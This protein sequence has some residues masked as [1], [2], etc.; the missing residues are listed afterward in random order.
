MRL[1]YAVA[2]SGL[3]LAAGAAMADPFSTYSTGFGDTP[4]DKVQIAAE[5][6]DGMAQLELGHRYYDG[7]PHKDDKQALFWFQKAAD[8]HIGWGE[9]EAAAMYANGEGTPADSGR[10]LALYES[11]AHD[12]I[13]RADADVGISYLT[14]DG[15][16]KDVNQAFIWFKAGADAGEARAE[17]GLG[18]LYRDGQGV[19]QDY[20]MAR[21]LFR[22]SAA[23]RFAP[24]AYNL[25][26]MIKRGQG[27]DKDLVVGQAWR[28]M[29][30][31]L[32]APAPHEVPK[33]GRV[34]GAYLVSPDL[35]KKQN[36]DAETYY[37]KL[38]TELG[39]D[40]APDA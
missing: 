22:A 15:V 30:K 37:F 14:G 28:I 12:G 19:T 4:I 20:A 8:Q 9:Y 17:C 16:A 10:A 26:D 5:A 34:V 36:E 39:F 7:L 32:E 40:K 21:K 31:Y 29:G 11:A 27:G 3:W 6:G 18:M 25:G 38:M 1:T 24:A 2:I 33:G 35:T 23:Q 13:V